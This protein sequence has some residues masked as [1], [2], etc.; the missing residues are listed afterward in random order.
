MGQIYMTQVKLSLYNLWTQKEDKM[1]NLEMMEYY[2]FGGLVM[3]V[4]IDPSS[5]CIHIS[6]PL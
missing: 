4:D 1:H 3:L 5:L 6:S 2:L